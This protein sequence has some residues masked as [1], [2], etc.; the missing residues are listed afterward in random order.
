MVS[1]RRLKVLS[2]VIALLV[3]GA[4]GTLAQTEEKPRYVPVSRGT[5]S[6]PVESLHDGSEKTF[7]EFAKA[8]GP[9]A[10]DLQFRKPQTRDALLIVHETWGGDGVARDVT[11]QVRRGKR[12]R[13]VGR[14]RNNFKPR[15]K[16]RF[17]KTRAR[18]WRITAVDIVHSRSRWKPFELSLLFLEDRDFPPDPT[19]PVDQKKINAA[20]DRGMDWLLKRWRKNGHFSGSYRSSYP[21]GT[22]A[23]GALALRKSGLKRSDPVILKLVDQLNAMEL[24]RVY[25]VS[26]YAMFLRSVS[27][28]R[29]T[30]KLQSLADWL[31]RK[32]RG[33]GLWGYPD[34]RA[35]VSNTQY[36]LLGLKAAVEGGARVDKKTWRRSWD[37]FLKNQEK[38]GAYRYDPLRQAK[39]DPV[40][41]SM[42]AAGLACL[43]IC[44]DQLP[45][46]RGRQRD[47][48]KI[49]ERSMLWM[50][51][52]FT[53]RVN[54]GTARWYYYYLYGVERVG[55]FFRKRHL[56]KRSWYADGAHAL[57]TK[58]GRKGSWGSYMEDTCFA[59]LFLNRA[60][61]TGD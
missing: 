16:L 20:I 39:H 59:L 23:L 5:G 4:G 32:Q 3:T 12:W 28:K 54:P 30:G 42:T 29:Y 47:S 44:M 52:Q 53:A 56:G 21:M 8:G 57:L 17:P 26:V 48:A 24:K 6:S 49:I 13:T 61:T 10:V 34:G 58:Q 51:Q 41:G 9:V 1:S 11:V 22:L 31:A 18:T 25:S 14:I 45:N 7:F 2:C 19:Y 27:R 55:A 35:D 46:D 50:G 40:S 33:E 38:V 15:L 36:A 43:K 37:W 60:S